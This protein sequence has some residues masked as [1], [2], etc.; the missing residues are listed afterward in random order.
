MIFS[1]TF[2]IVLYMYNF[3]FNCFSFII[4]LIPFLLGRVAANLN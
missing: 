1:A 4:L 2:L 3:V